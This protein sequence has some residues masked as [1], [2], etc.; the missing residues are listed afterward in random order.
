M[1]PNRQENWCCGGG[2][3]LVIAQEPEFRMMTSR[4]KADQIK[5]TG[6]A[7]VTTACEMCFA[8]LKDINDDFE[9]DMEVRLVSDLVA[10]ALVAG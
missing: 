2:G 4:V 8:Q 1:T 3:G 10:E 9:L 5:A 6:A 7:I